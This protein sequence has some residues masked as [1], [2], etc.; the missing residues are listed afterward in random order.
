MR[1]RGFRLPFYFSLYGEV[2]CELQHGF[3]DAG[4]NQTRHRLMLEISCKIRS[5]MPG[6][7]EKDFRQTSQ[8]LVA[9][10]VIVG[11]VPENYWVSASGMV[12]ILDGKTGI[13]S[14][15]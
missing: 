6:M 9:E 1:E 7:S 4:I 5:Q 15:G 10:T 14:S 13:N 8:I 11:E 2:T 3:D 12:P